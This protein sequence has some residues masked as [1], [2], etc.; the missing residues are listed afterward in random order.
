MKRVNASDPL[1]RPTDQLEVAMAPDEA[2]YSLSIAGVYQDSVTRYWAMQSCRRATQL[3]GEESVQDTWYNANSL[4]DPGI[5]LDAVRAALVADVIVVSVYA[6]DELPLDLYVWVQAWLPRRRSR[7]G[8]LTALI[9]VAEPPDSRFVR[10][11]EYLQAV[12]SR[13]Q[14]DFI[15]QE[16]KR[17]VPFDATESELIAE[18]GS[19]TAQ[20]LKELYGQQH[21]AYYRWRLNE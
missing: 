20:A 2:A 1:E 6:A 5:F 19:A 7:A 17:P 18:P 16:R 14:L 13:A 12:A 10:T 8:A 9:G 3:A 4:S 15:P 11:V 21:D